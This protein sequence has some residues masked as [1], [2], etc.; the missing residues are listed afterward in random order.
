MINTTMIKKI[1]LNVKFLIFLFRKLF[2]R[3]FDTTLPHSRISFS[4][5]T[6]RLFFTSVVATSKIPIPCMN[7]LKITA[8]LPN[9]KKNSIVKIHLLKSFNIKL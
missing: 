8:L 4:V 7:Y 5:S 2:L 9:N 1:S 6:N 3:E